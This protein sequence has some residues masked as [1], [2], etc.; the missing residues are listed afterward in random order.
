MPSIEIACI[1]LTKFAGLPPTTFAVVADPGLKS[2]RGP[3]PLFQADFDRLSGCLF[4]LG[5]RGLDQ[6][7]GGPFFADELLS[8][9]SRDADPASVLEFAPSYVDSLR[10]FMEWLL[11]VSPA[12]RLLFTSD[13]QFGPKEARRFRSVDLDAFWELHDSGKLLLNAAYPIKASI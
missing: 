7:V 1:G 13:W 8:A 9:R 11:S 4:H 5:N 12:Q 3:L 10:R 2:H 6:L